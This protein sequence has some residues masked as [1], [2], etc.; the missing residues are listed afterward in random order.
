MPQPPQFRDDRR[1]SI[2]VGVETSYSLS[3]LVLAYLRIDFLGM[4]PR[5][6]LS[7]HQILGAQMGIG[8]QQGL[9]ARTQA[10]GLLEKPNGNPGSD[11]TR[12]ATAH[13]RPRVDAWKIASQLPHDPS[14]DLSLLLTR[15]GWSNL[16]AGSL[17][18]RLS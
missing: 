18:D 4:R 14:E 9:L 10:P 11:D 13:I 5:I 6:G 15:K 12:L 2:F 17:A 3:G 16:L 7:V 8:S 1:G